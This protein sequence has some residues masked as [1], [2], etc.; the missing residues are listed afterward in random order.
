[1]GKRSAAT[2][3]SR[4]REFFVSKFS[5]CRETFVR[6]FQFFQNDQIIILA[7]FMLRSKIT[8]ITCF[9]TSFFFRYK[10]WS[11]S[12]IQNSTAAKCF[13]FRDLIIGFHCLLTI[14][15]SGIRW[16]W[17]IALTL[18][19]HRYASKYYLV[20]GDKEGSQRGE[21]EGIKQRHN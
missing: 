21:G 4:E 10:T 15:I 11:W 20:P 2:L 14:I 19:A 7:F 13:S 18:G 8:K 16:G 3:F 12:S 1:M 6:E 5:K 9:I 17:L